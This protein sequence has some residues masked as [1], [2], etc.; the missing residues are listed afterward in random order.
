MCLSSPRHLLVSRSFFACNGHSQ[1]RNS[2][3]VHS[4]WQVVDESEFAMQPLGKQRQNPTNPI[5]YTS[6]SGIWGELSASDIFA[7]INPTQSTFIRADI[8]VTFR[9]RKN[10]T[11]CSSMLCDQQRMFVVLSI[12]CC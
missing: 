3:V 8:L 11:C 1:Q 12:R 7:L 9:R 4:A 5:L 2:E 6:C 10:M